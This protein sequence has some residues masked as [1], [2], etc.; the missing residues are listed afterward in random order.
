MSSQYE[1][2]IKT[3]LGEKENAD[4][5]KTQIEN[6]GGKLIGKNKQLNHYFVVN[7]LSLFKEKVSSI[8]PE[9]KKEAFEKILTEGNNI[10][11]RTRGTEKQ[12][13]FV[14]KASL[15]SDT[16]SN[17]VSRI[18][19]EAILPLSLEELDQILINAGLSYQAKWSR[20][21]EEY[22]LGSVHVCIDRNA[23]YGY[24]AEFET[25]LQ[26]SSDVEE[27][28][29]SLYKLMKEFGVEELSQERI[30]R[31]FAYY[32]ENWRDYYGTDRIFV[33]Q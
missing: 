14:I 22:E 5:L 19:F 11:V 24:L 4:K 12:T 3:L 27:A 33:I 2:E 17:G 32:N 25:V 29:E 20:E 28:K 31:M 9:E 18:E 10:S 13:I 7:D 26:N 8:I 15:G 23:G 1:I 21:R 16:S 6:K 30:E